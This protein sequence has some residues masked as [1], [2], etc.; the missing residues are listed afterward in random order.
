MVGSTVDA[1]AGYVWEFGAGFVLVVTSALR[2]FGQLI[3]K[4]FGV[5]VLGAFEALW[6]TWWASEGFE[7]YPEVSY[8]V[9]A[10]EVLD[11][12]VCCNLE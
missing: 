8:V 2:A 10:L 9:D 3:A 11:W 5:P 7:G 4:V 12:S 6:W 1:F